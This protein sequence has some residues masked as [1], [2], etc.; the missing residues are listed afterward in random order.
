[1]RGT[2]FRSSY[3]SLTRRAHSLDHNIIININN[4]INN[5]NNCTLNL[6]ISV[7]N[8]LLKR[9]KRTTAMAASLA[10]TN[11]STLN[12]TRLLIATEKKISKA[13]NHNT[14][15]AAKDFTDRISRR[16]GLNGRGSRR[17]LSSS[18]A[19]LL[20]AVIE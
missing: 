5:N 6:N 1:M 2:H 16:D 17:V 12:R 10:S 19:A 14:A 18:T 3:S 11:A 8:L 7:F 9:Q 13:S 4:I 20:R 15:Y